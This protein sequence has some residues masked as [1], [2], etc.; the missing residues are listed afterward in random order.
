MYITKNIPFWNLF[1]RLKKCN[2]KYF[3]HNAHNQMVVYK[4][5]FNNLPLIIIE[6]TKLCQLIVILSVIYKILAF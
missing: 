6:W 5:L 3:N 4:Y 1:T 2:Y